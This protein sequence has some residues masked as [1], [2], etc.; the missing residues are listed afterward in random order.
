MIPSIG[1]IVIYKPREKELIKLGGN[2]ENGTTE[3]PAIIVN[4]WGDTEDSCANLKVIGD[5]DRN[6]WVTSASQG[7]AEGEWHEPTKK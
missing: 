3:C 2:H 6:I 1:R 5:S 7:E 4:V